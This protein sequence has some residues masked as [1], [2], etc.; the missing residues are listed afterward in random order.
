MGFLCLPTLGALLLA[1][2]QLV[3]GGATH[4]QAP[5]TRTKCR[6]HAATFKAMLPDN[7]SIENITFVPEGGTAGEGPKNILYP[8]NPT[9]LPELCAVTVNVTSSER[10][11]YRFGLFLPTQWKGKF[12]AVGNGGFGGGKLAVSVTLV[13]SSHS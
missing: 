9:K 13:G 2:S 11:S 5:G 10:S 7:A 3:D 6:C 8:V 12:Y 4:R 1:A